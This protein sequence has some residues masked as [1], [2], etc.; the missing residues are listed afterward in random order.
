[1]VMYETESLYILC[2]YLH[3]DGLSWIPQTVELAV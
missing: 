3:L 2:D 1:M